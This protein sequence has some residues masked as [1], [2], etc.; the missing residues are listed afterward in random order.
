MRI[1]HVITSLRTGGAEKLMT[2]LLPRIIE[3]GEDVELCVFDGVKTPFYEELERRDI[4]IHALG[5]SVYSPMNIIRLLSLI[6]KYDVVHTHN[7]ACQYYVAMAS[8]FTKCRLVTTE[9]N[10]L[11]RRRNIWWLLVDKW[12]YSRYQKILCISALVKKNLIRH[13]GVGFEQKCEVVHNGIDISLYDKNTQPLQQ[14]TKKRV[15]MVSAFRKQKD[16]KTLI[17]AFALLPKEYELVF[18]GGGEQ[19][20]IDEC[21]ILAERINIRDRVK[22]LGIR[23][24]VVELLKDADVVVLSSHYEGVSLS[25]LEGMASG[26]P[27]IASDVE[28]LRDIVGG[29]GILF[30]HEDYKTLATEIRRVCE[31]KDYC[32]DIV[33]KCQERARMFDI[34]VMVKKYLDVYKYGHVVDDEESGGT[35]CV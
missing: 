27:F 18:A 8:V 28:G 26:K 15:L 13:I 34:S 14:S 19:Y 20:L 12:V 21:S 35:A 29:Y 6:R 17:K 11:N 22:F 10:T 30:P 24:D 4:V 33:R 5:Q 31:D 16:H 9:H 32:I 3:C 7:T 1:L 2:E 23:T 25:S